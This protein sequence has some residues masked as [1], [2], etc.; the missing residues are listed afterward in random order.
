M[1]RAVL[2]AKRNIAYRFHVVGILEQFEDTL[3]LFEKLLPTFYGGAL[4]LYH[5]NEVQD[6]YGWGCFLVD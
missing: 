5:T 4:D 3:Q 2:L 6:T 1:Q